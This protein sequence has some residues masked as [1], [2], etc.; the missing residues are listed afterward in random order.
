MHILYMWQIVSKRTNVSGCDRTNKLPAYFPCTHRNLRSHIPKRVCSRE[1]LQHL[2]DCG[3]VTVKRFIVPPVLSLERGQTRVVIIIISFLYTAFHTMS[4]CI[5]S[6]GHWA[7]I[8]S[9]IFLSS[10]EGIQ[11]ILC[12]L[13]GATGL[14]KHITIST[15]RRY[16]FILLGK[17]KQ[18]Q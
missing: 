16:P 4:R 12:N 18:S 15:P 7:N 9:V 6:P 13:Y 11:P 5:N 10:L 8:I 1:V 2:E 3:R 14:I 17:E